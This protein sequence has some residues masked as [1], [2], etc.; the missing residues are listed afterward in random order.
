LEILRLRHPEL[1]RLIFFKRHEILKE[2]KTTNVFYL[3]LYKEALAN[4]KDIERFLHHS[5]N[6]GTGQPNGEG[7]ENLA[8]FDIYL[9]IYVQKN[10]ISI[11]E[12][13]KILDLITR[14]F[15]R[16]KKDN[17]SYDVN[18]SLPDWEKSVRYVSKF[19]RYFAQT[20]FENNIDDPDY[21]KFM[22]LYSKDELYKQIDL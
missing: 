19:E 6:N 16:R 17:E 5:Y 8:M 12:R 18:D 20:I 10:S 3:K 4:A 15:P 21:D 11:I 14:L 1:Y 2:H 7:E 9:D 13:D 22:I